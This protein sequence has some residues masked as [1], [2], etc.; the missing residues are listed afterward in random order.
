MVIA[1]F[2]CLACLLVVS[3]ARCAA[4]EAGTSNLPEG[5]YVYLGNPVGIGQPRIFVINNNG[6]V[7]WQGESRG[8]ALSRA[9]SPSETR[10]PTDLNRT[11]DEDS[12][13]QPEERLKPAKPRSE[14]NF[15]SYNYPVIKWKAK[16]VPGEPHG[17]ARK[18]SARGALRFWT[19][20]YE[21]LF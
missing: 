1:K 3:H 7:R 15:E 11:H 10:Q 12:R 16:A 4:Q 2:L 17:V 13:G 14:S 18:Y 5:M 6:Q 9:V 19:L 8:S 20:A 21:P